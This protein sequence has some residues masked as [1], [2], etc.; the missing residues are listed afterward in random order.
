VFASAARLETYWRR[1]IT[2]RLLACVADGLTAGSTMSVRFKVSRERLLAFPR[3]GDRD[4]AY[5]V[6][7]TATTTD[8]T[9]NVD[10]DVIVV[11]Q[12]SGVSALSLTNFFGPA[13]QRLE[14]R[15]ARLVAARLGPRSGA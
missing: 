3:V 1:V 4:C 9:V 15:L 13:P 12:G 7:G 2:R 5:R 8:Q 11:A 14:L 6:S 10:L